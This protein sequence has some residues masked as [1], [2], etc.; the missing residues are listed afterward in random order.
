MNIRRAGRYKRD[1]KNNRLADVFDLETQSCKP[2]MRNT[3]PTDN[4]PMIY[5]IPRLA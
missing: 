3:I 1:T 4:D 2:K 5:T